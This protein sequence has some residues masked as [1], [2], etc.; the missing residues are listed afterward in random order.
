MWD[1][2]IFFIFTPLVIL[3]NILR[4]T[5]SRHIFI[6]VLVCLWLA[7]FTY[8]TFRGFQ[9][10]VLLKRDLPKTRFLFPPAGWIMFYKVGST[11]GFYE[12]YGM[13]NKKPQLIDPHDIFRT[14]TIGYD[15]LHRG[16]LG[17]AAQK[18]RG[19]DFCRFLRYRFPYFDEFVISG[20]YLPKMVENPYE[21]YDNVQ[22]KCTY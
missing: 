17:S 21:R 8:E 3:V 22:Y 10:K 4:N 12:V 1:Y 5:R 20:V 6:T 19:Q 18:R 14:R 15:N 16:I 7:L 11:G 13:K 2:W 9:L